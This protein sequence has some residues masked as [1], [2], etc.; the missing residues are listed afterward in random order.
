MLITALP[1]IRRRV[2]YRQRCTPAP[3][4]SIRQPTL[5]RQDRVS[6]P[7]AMRRRPLRHLTGRPSRLMV[8]GFSPPQ[9]SILKATLIPTP[10]CLESIAPVASSV[11]VPH[12]LCRLEPIRFPLN[13]AGAILLPTQ[14][15]LLQP[16]ARPVRPA[17]SPT[18]QPILQMGLLPIRFH[19][20]RDRPLQLLPLL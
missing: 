1:I 18:P 17:I 9:L 2:T 16:P 5:A 12:R 13:C 10:R 20:C 7:A 14:L 4:H 11:V 15:R 6:P 8:T 19:V 3:E